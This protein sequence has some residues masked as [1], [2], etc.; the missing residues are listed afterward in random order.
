[1]TSS[2][3]PLLGL[4]AQIVSA[5]VEHNEIA[6]QALPAL[7]RDVYRTLTSLEGRQ[8]APPHVSASR[9]AAAPATSSRGQAGSAKTVFDD[10]L[11][12]MDCGIHMKMLKRHLQTVHNSS[13]EQYRAKWGLAG[14]YPMVAPAYASLR[15]SLAKESGLGK[16]PVQRGR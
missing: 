3:D 13:P 14:D 12:C 2:L 4:A 11:V 1:M 16:R 8:A 6:T 7:I 9:P 5:H 10:H 15:S